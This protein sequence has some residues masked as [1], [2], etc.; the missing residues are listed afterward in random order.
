M[1]P[2]T[3]DQLTETVHR[4]IGGGRI[5]IP[6]AVRWYV[7]T[8]ERAGTPKETAGAMLAAAGNWLGGE[9]VSVR[10]LGKDDCPELVIH[11]TWEMG[12]SA[13][14]TAAHG[15]GEPANDL[16][17]MGSRGAIY[18]GRTPEMVGG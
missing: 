11:A 4:A 10:T 3:L 9:P 1:E 14:I 17:L 7:R 18:F 8:N 13:L 12:A 6:S 16:I 15:P 2:S 5:G